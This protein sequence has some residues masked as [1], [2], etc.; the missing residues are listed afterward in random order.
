M[1][2]FNNFVEWVFYALLSGAVIYGVGILKGLKNAVE[3]LNVSVA[4]IIEK[5]SWHEKELERL[6]KRIRDLER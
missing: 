3:T 1:M 4:T 2:E 6:D 5:T